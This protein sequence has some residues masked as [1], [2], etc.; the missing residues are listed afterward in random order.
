MHNLLCYCSFSKILQ[1]VANKFNDV[2]VDKFDYFLRDA[3]HLKMSINFDYQRLMKMCRI[4]FRDGMT[5]ITFRDVEKYSIQGMFRV[6]AD[7]HIRAYQHKV[8]KNLEIM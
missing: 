8:V 4:E 6:R 1:V 7:L 3:Q 5:H 2:D